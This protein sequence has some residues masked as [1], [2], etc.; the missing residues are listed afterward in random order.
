MRSEH[1]VSFLYTGKPFPVIKITLPL[2]WRRSALT[3]C[4]GVGENPLVAPPLMAGLLKGAQLLNADEAIGKHHAVIRLHSLNR[5]WKDPKPL[6]RILSSLGTAA[7]FR[8][9][10]S[11]SIPSPAG[12][13]GNTSR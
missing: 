12:P 11:A 6:S 10:V 5:K 3:L 4:Q 9:A 8:T 2:L 7:P 1:L 13:L